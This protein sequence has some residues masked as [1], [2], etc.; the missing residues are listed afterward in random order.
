[1]KKKLRLIVTVIF[2]FSLF[3]TSASFASIAAPTNVKVESV[4]QTNAL[5]DAAKVEV[6]WD[7]VTGARGYVITATTAGEVPVQKTVTPGTTIRTVLEGLNGGVSYSFLVSSKDETG[8][9]PAAAFDFMPKSVPNPPIAGKIVTGKGQVTL[10]WAAPSNNGGLAVSSFAI[11]AT[12]VSTT[13]TSSE[14]S[15]VITGL[16]AGSEYTFQIK[17]INALGSS[18]AASYSAATIPSRPAAP[19]GV[20]ATVSGSTVSATWIAPTTTADAP[21]TGYTTHIY[22]SLGVEVTAKAGTATTTNYDFTGLSAGTYTVK[23]TAS[24]LVG[25]SDLS[26]ASTPQIVAV[27]GSLTTNKITLS[28]T[29]IS[30]LQIDSSF[31]LSAI[32]DSGGTVSLSVAPTSVCSYSPIT[33][34]VV[35]ISAGRCTITGTVDKSGNYDAGLASK[36]FYVVKISQNINFASISTQTMPGSINISV[37]SSSSL[38]VVVTASGGACSIVSRVVTFISAGVCTLTANASASSKYLAATPAVRYFQINPAPQPVITGGGVGT[39]PL[40]SP[41]PTPTPTPTVSTS[42][43]STPTTKATTTPTPSSAPTATHAATPTPIP[44]S[45]PV[46]TFQVV[47]TKPSSTLTLNSGN[48]TKALSLS[49]TVQVNFGTVKKGTAVVQTIKGPTGTFTLSST[50]TKTTGAVKSPVLKFS[51]PGTY[52]LTITIGKTK[53]VITFK[54]TK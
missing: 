33:G 28:P 24:N 47:T 30:D 7:A 10:N 11:T 18:V 40:P 43:T 5:T 48:T 20:S 12:G 16:T 45:T 35:G 14:T 6:S 39:P 2:A 23:V 29:T 34:S 15:K 53:K 22:D 42:P 19:T 17:A 3:G 21:V 37:S 13:A 49:K 50:K 38:P 52:V 1:M 51:K 46:K 27:A 32:A 8:E 31:A 44:S 36:D 9:Y 25:D 41:T 4:S 26:A 54:V